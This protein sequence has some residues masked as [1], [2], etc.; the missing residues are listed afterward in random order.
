[1]NLPR[2][3]KAETGIT[4]QV[5]T[6]VKEKV[7]SVRSQNS[8]PRFMSAENVIIDPPGKIS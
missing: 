2:Y 7:Y 4:R 5:C 1:M 8:L 6:S 3:L